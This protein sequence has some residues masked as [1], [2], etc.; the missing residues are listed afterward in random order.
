MFSSVDLFH[1]FRRITQEQGG[2]GIHQLHFDHFGSSI[3]PN[4]AAPVLVFR[5]STGK[6][7]SS[8]PSGKTSYPPTH[9]QTNTE[10]DNL[11][12]PA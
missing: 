1:H 4:R 7:A 6:S 11:A 10:S 8:S 12:K 9:Y 5:K 2:Y 3:C